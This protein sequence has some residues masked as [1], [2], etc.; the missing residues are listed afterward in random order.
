MSYDNS[1]EKDCNI[2][3]NPAARTAWNGKGGTFSSEAKPLREISE[4][5]KL[6]EAFLRGW[7]SVAFM[8]AKGRVYR[9]YGTISTLIKE[10]V[11]F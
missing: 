2:S 7:D 9:K 6:L 1:N 5:S 11:R 4:I 10:V 3:S 8:C